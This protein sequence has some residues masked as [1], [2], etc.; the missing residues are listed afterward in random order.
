MDV[1]TLMNGAVVGAELIVCP[2]GSKWRV[3]DPPYWR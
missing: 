1:V 2:S 3:L